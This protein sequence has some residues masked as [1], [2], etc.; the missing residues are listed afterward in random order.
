MN[1]TEYKIAIGSPTRC[2][3]GRGRRR[4]AGLRA[5]PPNVFFAAGPDRCSKGPALPD[6]PTHSSERTSV[7]A[8]V[9]CDAPA[10]RT[11]VRHACSQAGREHDDRRRRDAH[12][13]QG[14]EDRCSPRRADDGRN[15]LVLAREHKEKVREG[16][17]DRTFASSS[18]DAPFLVTLQVDTVLIARRRFTYSTLPH[19][20][21][22]D[23]RSVPI[24]ARPRPSWG[25]VPDAA[26]GES[27]RQRVRCSPSTS[28]LVPHPASGAR[29]RRGQAHLAHGIGLIVHRGLP[30]VEYPAHATGRVPAFASRKHVLSPGVEKRHCRATPLVPATLGASREPH[31]SIVTCSRPRLFLASG[32]P[33]AAQLPAPDP[34]LR[35]RR[36][37]AS[38]PYRGRRV[39]E[40]PSK[41]DLGQQPTPARAEEALPALSVRFFRRSLANLFQGRTPSTPKALG[42]KATLKEITISYGRRDAE[43]APPASFPA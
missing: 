30:G 20:L 3:R 6:G 23:L 29:P 25:T 1:W 7:G 5:P 27:G 28:S 33:P 37:P 13:N 24:T 32:R 2:S 40:M 43:D 21:P 22:K 36:S 19:L 15:P 9:Q 42:G 41:E 39:P 31:P 10:R 16:T 17:S 14:R 35:V 18:D 38:T 11:S 8:Q 12:D 4:C 26:R 34:K